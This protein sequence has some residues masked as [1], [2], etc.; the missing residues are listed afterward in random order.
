MKQK[1]KS[2]SIFILICALITL[3]INANQK[4]TFL[5]GEEAVAKIM[6]IKSLEKDNS[7]VKKQQVTFAVQDKLFTTN[8]PYHSTNHLNLAQPIKI[9]KDR[10][11]TT[12]VL[13]PLEVKEELLISLFLLLIAIYFWIKAYRLH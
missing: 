11:N 2:T 9:V 4:K 7:S 13:D 6:S 12:F 3:L 1:L 8:I 10:A 5:F